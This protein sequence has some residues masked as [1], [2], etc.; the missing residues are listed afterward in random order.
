MPSRTKKRSSNPKHSSRSGNPNTRDLIRTELESSPRG[1]SAQATD[2]ETA[3][4]RKKPRG[5][6][7]RARVAGQ[8]YASTGRR[9][10]AP[11]R[12]QRPRRW[13][14]P[15]LAQKGP[16]GPGEGSYRGAIKRAGAWGQDYSTQTNQTRSAS[17]CSHLGAGHKKRA[18]PMRARPRCFSIA[19]ARRGVQRE[20]QAADASAL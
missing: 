18:P 19:R 14:V 11:L 9:F 20:G 12:L 4:T 13:V 1:P 10:S 16:A 5:G 8:I 17:D 2:M 3:R 15:I 7:G 6:P